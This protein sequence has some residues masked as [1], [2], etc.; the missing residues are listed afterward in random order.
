MSQSSIQVIHDQ[1]DALPTLPAT[2]TRVLAIT[3]DPESSAQDLM[4]AILPDQTMCATIL[5]IANSA[6]FGIPKEVNTIERALMVLGFDE[7]KNIII[8]KAIFSSFPKLNKESIRGVG[9]FW[10]HA[11]TCGLTSK[12]IAEHYSLSPS[13]LFMSGLIHDIGKLV[14]LMAFPNSYPI[15]EEHSLANHFHAM[16]T[17]I[18]QYGT[19][20]DDVGLELARRWSLPEQLACAIGYHHKPDAAPHCKQHPMIVQVA[21]TLSLIYCCS[22]ITEA[23]DV[24][25]IFSQFLPGTIELWKENGL[26]LHPE[27]LGRWFETLQKTREQDQPIL[28]L[29]SSQ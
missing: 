5:K 19:R 24:Q 8:G 4:Q 10:E 22:E 1:I 13:D 11:F 25:N 7:I 27:S 20:H 18:E 12:I 26:I 9:V 3:S 28:T 29:L 21:D 2:V 15:L 17:E 14:M 16:G 6:A 23:G